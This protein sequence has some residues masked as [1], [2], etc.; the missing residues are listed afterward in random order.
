MGGRRASCIF[1]SAVP[2]VPLGDSL[3]PQP[4]VQWCREQSTSLPLICEAAIANCGQWVLGP[5]ALLQWTRM[6]A[7]AGMDLLT[8]AE[9]DTYL[10]HVQTMKTFFF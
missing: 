4:C 3:S 7:S 10:E 5:L 2:R 1:A 9:E 6:V 8:G